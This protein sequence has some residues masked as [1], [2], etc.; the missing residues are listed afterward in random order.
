[1]FSDAD[2]EHLTRFATGVDFENMEESLEKQKKLNQMLKERQERMKKD[3][4]CY[5]CRL[6]V[7]MLRILFIRLVIN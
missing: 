7:Y 2:Y 4:I 3:W 5:D 6:S 1:M